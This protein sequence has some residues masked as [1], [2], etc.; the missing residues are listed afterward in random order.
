MFCADV[1]PSLHSPRLRW[2]GVAGSPSLS[3]DEDLFAVN[4]MEDPDRVTPK[5]H[6]S[7]QVVETALEAELAEIV[8]ALRALVAAT[9]TETK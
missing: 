4:T 8:A 5:P 9:A 3:W 1:Q 6:S 2:R 7:A